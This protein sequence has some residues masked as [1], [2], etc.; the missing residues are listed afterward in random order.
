MWSNLRNLFGR[1]R[2]LVHHLRDWTAPKLVLKALRQLP[3]LL[4]DLHWRYVLCYVSWC[5]KVSQKWWALLWCLPR[6]LLCWQYCISTC[7]HKLP[8]RMRDLHLK[9]YVSDLLTKILQYSWYLLQLSWIMCNLY[10]K[11]L[12]PDLLSCHS[13]SIPRINLYSYLSKWILPKYADDDLRW[14]SCFLQ[15]LQKRWNMRLF[16]D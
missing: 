1:R 13:L 11:Y 16:T 5:Q 12:L 8:H 4:S 3:L 10:L 15:P 9:Y 14:L 6:W 2:L 7:M